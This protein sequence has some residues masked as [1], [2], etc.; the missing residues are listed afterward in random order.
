MLLA[1]KNRRSEWVIRDLY[2][3][4]NYSHSSCTLSGKAVFTS[5][6]LVNGCNE[7]VRSIH[8]HTV[9]QNVILTFFLNP[10]THVT[11]WPYKMYQKYKTLSDHGHNKKVLLLDS[12]I[13]HMVF[14]VYSSSLLRAIIA[15][16]HLPFLKIC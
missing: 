12:K 15:H 7:I 3:I 11:L 1:S 2:F 4:H 9:M 6:K 14:T 10:P 16:D 8:I 5:V 13:Y